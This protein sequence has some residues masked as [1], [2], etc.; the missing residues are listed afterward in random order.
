LTLEKETQAA[1]KF[2][3][4]EPNTFSTQQRLI[5]T[6][7]PVFD[8]AKINNGLYDY[9][10][11]CDG[12]NNTPSVIDNNQLAVSI[13]IQPVKTAEFILCDFIATQTGVNFTELVGQGTL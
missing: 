12:R 4:F 9:L 13:Y 11:V 6:L 3:L 7:K 8:N 1:L 10:I 5:N 2:F